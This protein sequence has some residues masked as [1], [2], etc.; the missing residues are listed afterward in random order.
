MKGF[1][2][3]LPSPLHHNPPPS[4]L[5]FIIRIQ[6]LLS[7]PTFYVSCL[8]IL[9]FVFLFSTL[10]PAS[11]HALFLSLFSLFYRSCCNNTCLS[12]ALLLR[13]TAITTHNSRFSHWS[14]SVIMDNKVSENK[15]FVATLIIPHRIQR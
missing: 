10:L 4:A 2:R 7:F 6:S 11:I 3:F 14:K 5:I 1:R 9:H 13:C 8:P 15:S 12:T